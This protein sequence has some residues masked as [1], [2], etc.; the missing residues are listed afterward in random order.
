LKNIKVV[1]GLT[2]GQDRATSIVYGM[3]RAAL[4]Q[5]AVARILAL[6]DIAGEIELAVRK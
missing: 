3:P 4:E 1:G 6:P 2:I 5:G